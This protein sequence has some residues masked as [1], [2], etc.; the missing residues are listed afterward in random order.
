[1]KTVSSGGVR[2]AFEAQGSADRPIL[3]LLH[4]LGTTHALWDAER[5]ELSGS[6]QVVCPDFRGHGA[7]DVPPGPYAVA[8]LGR[9]VLAVLD[10]VGPAARPV[11]VC[12]ISLGGLVALWLALR[13]G[14]RLRTATVACSAARVGTDESWQTRMDAVARGGIPAV[15]DAVLGR[16]FSPE[17]ARRSPEVVARI[18]ALL[19][20]TSPEGYLAC[21]AALR[22]EDLRPEARRTGPPL[23]VI[24]GEKDASCPPELSRWLAAEAPGAELVE[25]PAV[26]HLAHLERPDLFDAALSRFLEAH[27]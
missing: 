2:I 20:A 25:I 6:Y 9:D 12:G 7:S 8:D 26:A 4:A 15:R 19:D 16:F 11:H 13:H 24:A 21:C 27:A 23:L 3:L 1:M 5:E 10:A 14:Q 17:F 18:A 22:A